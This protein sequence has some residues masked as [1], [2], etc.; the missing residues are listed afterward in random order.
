MQIIEGNILGITSG[1]ICH[2]VNCRGVFNA[3]LAKQIRQ[4]YPIVYDGY[5]SSHKQGKLKLGEWFCYWIPGF[6]GELA[7]ANL[8]GQDG[9]GT[10]KCYT[11][12]EALKKCLQKIAYAFPEEQIY[13]PHGMGCRLAGGDWNIVSGIIDE[14]IPDAIVV[15]WA[16]AQ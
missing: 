11:D 6:Y 5:M 7:I 12:Y 15:K 13:F 2:Q 16:N 8:V 10:D 9:Y 14:V 1:I 4:K 3:G